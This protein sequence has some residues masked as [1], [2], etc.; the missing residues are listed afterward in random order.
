MSTNHP[1]GYGYPTD[2]QQNPYAQ[3]AGHQPPPA[4]GYGAPPPPPPGP[5]GYGPGAYGQPGSTAPGYGAP[6]H[7]VPGQGTPGYGTP[8]YGTPGYGAP[9]YG[10][11]G[12]GAPGYGQPPQ[13]L[14]HWL[15]PAGPPGVPQAPGTRVLAPP[16]ERLVARL[17]DLAIQLIPAVILYALLGEWLGNFF[18]GLLAFAYEAALMVTQHGQ[19][20]G[21]KAMRLRVVDAA[22]GGRPTDSALWGRSAVATVPGA[23][24]CIGWLFEMLDAAWQLWDKPLQQCLHDK[25]VRT[26][27]VKEG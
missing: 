24:Y 15:T 19:T 2:P 22:T 20:V 11:P 8:E 27:V 4:P 3:Q 25:A 6:G 18:V 5:P 7:G 10:T 26:V 17:I 12:Y 21:K 1:S 13:A 14:P 23:V 9:G 16:G